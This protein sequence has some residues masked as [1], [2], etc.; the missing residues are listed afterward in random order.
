MMLLFNKAATKECSFVAALLM[1]NIFITCGLIDQIV[2]AHGTLFK[3]YNARKSDVQVWV[4][5]TTS[6]FLW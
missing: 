6:Y 3:K 2:S 4:Q 5:P 1:Q